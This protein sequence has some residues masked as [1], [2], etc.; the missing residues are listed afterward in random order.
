MN[1]SHYPIHSRSLALGARV[2]QSASRT[3]DRQIAPRPSDYV[4]DYSHR[5]IRVRSIRVF[6]LDSRVM[7]D[8]RPSDYATTVRVR[9]GLFTLSVWIRSRVLPLDNRTRF[10][11]WIC[12]HRWQRRC[13]I[14]TVELLECVGTLYGFAHHSLNAGFHREILTVSHTRR[15]V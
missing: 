9:H 11:S 14:L 5:R 3:C 6:T 8:L 15:S 4:M 13:W 7:V 10:N 1:Y 2:I 12:T